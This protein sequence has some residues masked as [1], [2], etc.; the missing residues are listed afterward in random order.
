MV[1]KLSETETILKTYH[2]D[3][4]LGLLGLINNLE[5]MYE[6]SL[7]TKDIFDPL[8]HRFFGADF[9]KTVQELMHHTP[10]FKAFQKRFYQWFDAFK[11]IKYLHFMRD[12]CN[13]DIS[14]NEAVR[15][16]LSHQ[17]VDTTGLDLKSMLL[18]M[19]QKDRIIDGWDM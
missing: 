8:L 16:A 10:D 3:H 12:N 19:R 9:E 7:K 18:I 6:G 4:Y 5:R 17:G 11:L 13:D 15:F 14:V 1:K 2:Y